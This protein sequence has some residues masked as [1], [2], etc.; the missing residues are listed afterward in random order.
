VA[1]YGPPPQEVLAPIPREAFVAAV[2]ANIAAMGDWL[3]HL[4]GHRGQ[5]YA[6]LLMCRAL[7]ATTHGDQLSKPAAGRWAQGELPEWAALIGRA[8]AWHAAPEDAPGVA[9]DAETRRFV[10]AVR[11]RILA[12]PGR[13][14]PAPA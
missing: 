12:Q 14:G 13:A 2:R 6:I 9:P 7:R 5:A 1:L 3:D 10:E 11:R 4:R 8:I